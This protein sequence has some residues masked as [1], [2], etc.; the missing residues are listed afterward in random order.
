MTKEE[1]IG[2]YVVYLQKGKSKIGKITE[3][4]ITDNGNEYLTV[5]FNGGIERKFPF[6]DIISPKYKY[7]FRFADKEVE[8]FVENLFIEKYVHTEKQEPIKTLNH[9]DESKRIENLT[10]RRIFGRNIT[11]KF[12]QILSDKKLTP[13]VQ[14]GRVAK[15]IYLECCS[16]FGFN[17]RKAGS[18]GRQR[19]LYDTDCTVEGYDVWMLPHSD[20]TGDT[21]ENWWNFIDDGGKKIIQYNRVKDDYSA[22]LRLTFV[23]QKNGYYVYMGIYSLTNTY[24]VHGKD[25]N[26]Y[27]YVAERVD[28]SEYN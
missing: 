15:D 18:F 7:K 20:L 3:I 14:Y 19:L 26:Y 2:T 10:N 22:N 23:K 16:A 17:R 27:A 12:R 5:S 11:N 21:N 28:E 6:P 25:Q 8:K 1:M 4:L 13:H 9:D 24:T